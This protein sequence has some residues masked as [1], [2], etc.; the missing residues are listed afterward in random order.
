[1]FEKL[2]RRPCVV[3]KYREAPLRQQRSRYLRHL[4]HLGAR[5]STLR[6]VA[7]AQHHL[8]QLLDLTKPANV[9]VSRIEAAVREWPWP[10]KPGGAGQAT[11]R[12]RKRFVA[13][14]VQWLRFLGWLDEPESETGHPH[15]AEVAAFAKWARDVRGYSEQTIQAYCQTIDAFFCFMAP[16][17]SLASLRISDVDRAITAKADQRE[18]SRRTIETYARRLRT[19]FRFSEDRGWC[20]PSI[21]DGIATPRIYAGETIATGLARKD[22]LRLLTT[23]EGDL[24]VDKRDRAILMLLVGYGLRSGELRGL[25]LDDIDWE[26]ETLRV[27]RSKSGRTNIYPLSRGVGLTVLRYLRDVRPLGPERTLFLTLAAPI[28]PLTRNA[29]CKVFEK[30]LRQLGIV[31]RRLGPHAVRHAAAQHLLDQGM[32]MKAIGDFLGHR[33]PSSTAVYAKVDVKSLRE[34]AN[35]NL[36]GLT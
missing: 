17:V 5:K 8:V 6:A 32:S 28:R 13:H 16:D 31:G 21:S 3:E 10:G 25:Q 22:V 1:M 27:R 34:V 2:Y 29:L 12:T 23:T 9:N 36:G 35:F 11:S 18:L 24:P 4:A 14:A 26:E 20:M 7:V 33:N 19:F 30:R 15:S